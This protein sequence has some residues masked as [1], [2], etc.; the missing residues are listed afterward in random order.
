M[1]VFEVPQCFATLAVAL[2]LFNSCIKLGGGRDP[3]RLH[4]VAESPIRWNHLPLLERRSLST[5]RRIAGLWIAFQHHADVLVALGHEHFRH[6]I[7]R[8]GMLIFTP[9]L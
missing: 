1:P 7:C 5:F 6:P 3:N 4:P 8:D 2:Q 9:R